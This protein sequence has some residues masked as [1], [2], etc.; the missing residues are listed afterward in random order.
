MSK[1]EAELL[2]RLLPNRYDAQRV[3]GEATIG[4]SSR[5]DTALESLSAAGLVEYE[6]YLKH[7]GRVF[8]WR[9]RLNA[10]SACCQTNGEWGK[11]QEMG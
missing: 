7:N 9:Y 5:I 6:P 11:C 1:T 3:T 4:Q 8:G 2:S 10:W